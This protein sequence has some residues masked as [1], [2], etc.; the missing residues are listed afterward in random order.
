M[1]TNTNI[2]R[3][4]LSA[5]LLLSSPQSFFNRLKLQKFLFLY[6][7]FSYSKGNSYDFS[8]LKGYKNGPVFS[9]VYGDN[10]WREDFFSAT[11][12]GISEQ[13]KK[14]TVETEVDL[15]I[16]E[17]ASFF[18]EVLSK[19]EL[20][21]L[22]HEFDIW[23]NK[24]ERIM[25]GESQVVLEEADFSQNDREYALDL[26]DL[27]SSSQIQNWEIY[28]VNGIAFLLEK[29]QVRFL[30]DELSEVLFNI[31]LYEEENPVFIEIVDGVII[32]DR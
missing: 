23:K 22:T 11:V 2:R 16:V 27:Y 14:L 19:N 13:L 15:E 5:Y 9:D 1:Y 30:T 4:R 29:D 25:S 28:K 6:E 10:A 20:S 8:Y 32:I 3:L 31:S 18:V 17:K 7:V 24:E 26:F 21:E 12:T